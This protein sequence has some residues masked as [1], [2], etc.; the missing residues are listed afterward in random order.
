LGPAIAA[1]MVLRFLPFFATSAMA[2]SMLPYFRRAVLINIRI[3][4]SVSAFRLL[5]GRPRLSTN[6]NLGLFLLGGS[7]RSANFCN[8]FG[9]Q[10]GFGHFGNH[11]AEATLVTIR[12]EQWRAQG[13]RNASTENPPSGR[14][15][16]G[17]F[18][19]PGPF[20][21]PTKTK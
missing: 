4:P 14:S 19:H 9:L 21:L 12:T 2:A 5:T 10:A 3:R 7:R 20:W 13:P 11:I 16:P 1:K 17:M 18:E 15:Q 6:S 8:S